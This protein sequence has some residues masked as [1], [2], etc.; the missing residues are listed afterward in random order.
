ME[1]RENSLDNV[2]F[3]SKKYFTYLVTLF[4]V[5]WR[6]FTS[7][8]GEAGLRGDEEGLPLSFGIFVTHFGYGLEAPPFSK[9]HTVLLLVVVVRARP[10]VF[11]CA[12]A[13]PRGCNL[14]WNG[15]EE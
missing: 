1:V 9:V 14:S 15:L 11:F 7:G 5:S 4:S 13:S 12:A 3:F 2:N 10:F 8:L 6:S